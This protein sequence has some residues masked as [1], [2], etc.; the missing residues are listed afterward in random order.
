MMMMTMRRIK[1]KK[2]TSEAQKAFLARRSTPGLCC[3]LVTHG[4]QM[5]TDF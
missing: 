2:K 1:E 5:K 3:F 4:A